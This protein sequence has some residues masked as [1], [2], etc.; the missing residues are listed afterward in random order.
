MLAM[1]AAARLSSKLPSRRHT[2]AS[3]PPGAE[4]PVARS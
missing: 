1:G 3:Q 2:D 4:Q